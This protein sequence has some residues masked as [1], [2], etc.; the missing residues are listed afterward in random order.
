MIYFRIY[1]MYNWNSYS[2]SNSHKYL[3]LIL[4]GAAASLAVIVFLIFFPQIESINKESP[5]LINIMFIPAMAV[6]FLYGVRITQRAVKPSEMRSPLKSS[7]VKLFLFIFVIGGMFGSVNF[8]INGGSVIPDVTILEDGL[9]PWLN[10]FVTANGGA[11]FMIITSITLMAAASKRVVGMTTGFLNR[12]VTFVGTFVFFTMLVLSFTHSDPTSS[13]VFLYTFYQAG[14]VGG[15]F[16]AM[17]K[18]TKNQNTL[19][20]FAKGL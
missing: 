8:A 9:L 15:A 3:G 2:E 13:G 6:G 19:Q 7:I 20:D 16:Y 11:T 5:L 17:N 14:I 12:M 4:F 18:L 10:K 1:K